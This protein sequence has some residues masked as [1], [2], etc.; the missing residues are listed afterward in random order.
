MFGFSMPKVS[1]CIP[2]FGTE[3]LL[4]E[5][6]QSVA[7]QD[8][9]SAE[10]IVVNDASR[11]RDSEGKTCRQI[12]KAFQKQSPFKVTYIEHSEN[13]GLLEARRTAIYAAKGKFIACVDS[14]DKL[15]PGALKALYDAAELN[16]ADIVHGSSSTNS[17]KPRNNKIYIGELQGK[18]ILE[19]WL[20][21]SAYNDALWGKLIDRELYLEALDKIPQMYCNMAEDIVQ[22]FFIALNA[23]KYVG[24]TNLVYFYN[25]GSGMTARHMISNKD[26]LQG[27]VSAASV[28]TAIHQWLQG[29][30]DRTGKLAI[31]GAELAAIRHFSHQYMKNNLLQVKECVVPE[32]QADARELLCEYWGQDF[33][34]KTEEEMNK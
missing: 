30:A 9:D 15:L 31:S 1:V 22:W 4:A 3:K 14:D 7:E 27:I 28:F 18:Q 33:V 12:V 24:I 8:F 32:L 34:E 11:G 25:A 16:K 17:N 26:D 21:K 19:Q 10:I 6:L 20:T 29:E 5:C 2:V 13:L 23:K